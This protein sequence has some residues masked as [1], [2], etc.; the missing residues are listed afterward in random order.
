MLKSITSIT[1]L[2]ASSVLL[3]GCLYEEPKTTADGE[4]GVDPTEVTVKANINL[5]LQLPSSDGKTTLERPLAGEKPQFRHRF[6]IETFLNGISAGRQVVYKDIIDGQSTITLPV[7]MK[8][9]A[10]NYKIAVWSDYVQTPDEAN[11]ITGT[12]EYF[13]DTT[14]GH[15]QTVLMNDSYRGNNE[16]KDAFC[17]VAEADLESYRNQWG[18][19]VN[20]DIDLKRPVARYELK[21]NDVS[22][23]LGNISAGIVKGTTFTVRLRYSNY[24]NTGYNVLESL[25]RNGLM[26]MQYEKTLKSADLKAGEDFTLAF[27]YVFAPADKTYRIPVTLEVIDSSQKTIA[28]T[29]FNI[30]AQAGMNY[31]FTKNFLTAGSGDGVHINPDYSGEIETDIPGTVTGDKK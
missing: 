26:Y 2:L 14:S 19:L 25:P 1:A 9:H 21:T 27:D 16:Y 8:L 23:F 12:E 18:A 4:D 20:L 6:V 7:S 17:G 24:L 15:L 22:K 10:R 28:S 29:S 30:V 11:G 3:T 5:N 31:T 13:Y